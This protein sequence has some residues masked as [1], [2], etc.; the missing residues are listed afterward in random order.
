[1]KL[2][3]KLNESKFE[4]FLDEKLYGEIIFDNN[5]E[6]SL[7]AD[8]KTYRA[9]RGANKNISL[10]KDGQTL[11]TFNFDYVWGGAEIT[12]DGIDTGLDI[13]GRWFKPGTRL[14][15]IDDNDLIVAVKKGDGLEVKV[16]DESISPEMILATI[17]YHIYTS[18][19]K[20]L[21]VLIAS[22]V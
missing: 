18:E 17:Y 11:C 10:K 15:D 9:E 13:R 19:G 1:M 14:T 16:I 21:S 7:I 6:A 3:V 22:V 4:V 2:I 8:N 12:V 20:M 5:V